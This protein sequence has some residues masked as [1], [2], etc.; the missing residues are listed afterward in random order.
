MYLNTSR[1]LGTTAHKSWLNTKDPV[2]EVKW[3]KMILLPWFFFF[4]L[5]SFLSRDV[6]TKSK[7]RT[8][9]NWLTDFNWL[10]S[11]S[12]YWTPKYWTFDNLVSECLN[13]VT[14]QTIWNLDIFFHLNIHFCP[15]F[16]T[17]DWNLDH[18]MTGHFGLF[19]LVG[20][21]LNAKY[22]HRLRYKRSKG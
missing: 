3:V 16:K 1:V 13:Y 12:E 7:W 6:G 11:P 9:A 15:T 18:S 21:L 8:F 4:F 2:F 19:E 10:Q 20:W 17:T 14:K 22:L 5:P